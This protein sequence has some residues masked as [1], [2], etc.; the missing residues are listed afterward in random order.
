[1]AQALGFGNPLV[2]AGI[3]FSFVLG[4]VPLFLV[5]GVFMQAASQVFSKYFAP[6][7]ATLVIMLAVWN[8]YSAAIIVGFQPRSVYCEIVY[9]EDAVLPHT[10]TTTPHITIHATNYEI[11]NPYIKAGSTVTVT[12]TNTSGA[13]CIQFFTIPQLQIQ[14]IISVGKEETITFTA[15]TKKGDLL[16]MCSMGMYRGK[17][18][19]Q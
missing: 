1:M 11:D 12:I 6:V 5:F 13:G 8:I 14:K 18:I 4:T 2:S 19:V 9:C 7:A 15:P 17:F 10:I 3:L 16:F